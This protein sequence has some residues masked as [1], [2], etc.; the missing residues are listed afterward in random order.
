[1]AATLGAAYSPPSPLELHYSD[2]TS[3]IYP[4]RPIRPL[5]KRRLRSRLSSEV[6]D[7]ILYPPATTL[8]KPVFQFPYNGPTDQQNGSPIRGHLP[9]MESSLVWEQRNGDGEIDSYQF[10]GAEKSSDDED[11]VSMARRYHEQRQR[12]GSVNNMPR[13]G[14]TLSRGDAAKFIKP[15][16]PQ[17]TASSGDSVDGYDSFENTNNKKKRKIPT[18]GSLGSHQTSLSAEMAQ[19]GIS[20]TRDMDVA[21]SE[22]DSGV[23]HYYGTGNSAV[24]AV[25]SGTGISGAGRGRY[26]RAGARYHSGRSP[27]GV[28]VNGSNTLQVG[29][30][31]HHRR[32]YAPGSSTI[33]GKEVS[34]AK[35]VDRGIISAAIAEAAASPSTPVK[36]QENRSLLEQQSSKRSGSAKTQFTFTCESDSAKSMVWP[37]DIDFSPSP[38]Q[39][40]SRVVSNAAG[41]HQSQ[42]GRGVATQG[43][44]T[45]PNIASQT[46][47][48]AAH[49]A[50]VNQQ[51]PQQTKKPRRPLHKQY[52]LAAR[53]RRTRQEINN[54]KN[55]PK[56]E[57]VWICEFCEYES[58]FHE[59]P[60]ALI[61][62]YEAKD[63]L[64]R[65]RAAEKQRLLEKAKMKGRKG[66]KGNKKNANAA[67]HTQ[68]PA[69]K[70]R[71]DQQPMDQIPV[72]HQGTQSEEY[73]LDDYDDDPIPMPALPT[74]IPSKI[75]QPIAQ[76]HS[77]SLRPSSSSGGMKS[78]IGADRK[79]S[80]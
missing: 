66:K 51:A 2:T 43:T 80:S 1:M 28:S 60:K 10:R 57:D 68:Q 15:P 46:N 11:G 5:P 64:E 12:P 70:P 30:S 6:A 75:P 76:N 16:I 63:R 21:Q 50:G 34:V 38:S 18:S 24:P 48:G 53:N 55:P 3:S 20:S 33:G 13:N 26:G 72:Q 71:Y 31:F 29:R 78:G 59:P 79:S 74:Q 36:G 47:E 65:K 25:S 52:A 7:S 45:S 17:S 49:Q 27:L 14:Y 9:E 40:Y 39:P 44:Q 73:M 42:N 61:R 58:I 22:S 35:S 19:M 62:Q 32:D 54:Y 4:D 56:E 23:G 8:S 41:V 69:Q 77:H 37:P 67:T